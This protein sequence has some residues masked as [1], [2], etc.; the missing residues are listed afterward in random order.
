MH[1]GYKDDPSMFRVFADG[2]RVESVEFKGHW[3][4]L[5]SAGRIAAE[6]L[7]HRDPPARG[8]IND[9]YKLKWSARYAG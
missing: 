3:M 6:V 1:K 2:K 5:D 4:N 7:R 9:T 8:G